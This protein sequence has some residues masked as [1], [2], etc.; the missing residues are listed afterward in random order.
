MNEI[1]F[2][3][4]IIFASASAIIGLVA[5]ILFYIS[6]VKLRYKFDKEYGEKPSKT[7]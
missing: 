4:G 7:K 1:L 5:L 3:G 6:G 2:Y